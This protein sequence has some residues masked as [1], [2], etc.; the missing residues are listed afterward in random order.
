MGKLEMAPF[1]APEAET[2]IV[3]GALTEY[4]GRGLALFLLGRE[5]ELVGLRAEVE[6]HVDVDVEVHGLA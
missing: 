4:S 2:E 1:D 5:V 3:A 6:V